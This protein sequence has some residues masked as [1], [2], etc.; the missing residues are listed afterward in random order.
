VIMLTSPAGKPFRVA[1][2]G[3]IPISVGHSWPYLLIGL[4]VIL[5]ADGQLTPATIKDGAKTALLW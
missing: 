4:L 3:K 1:R 5:I 2:L